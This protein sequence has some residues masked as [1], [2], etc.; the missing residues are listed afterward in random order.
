MLHSQTNMKIVYK[1]ACQILTKR[2]NAASLLKWPFL[3]LSLEHQILES[4]S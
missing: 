2:D 1:I 4:G 3:Q